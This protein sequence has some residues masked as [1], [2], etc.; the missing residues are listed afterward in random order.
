MRSVAALQALPICGRD[1]NCLS[2]R[3]CVHAHEWRHVPLRVACC[4]YDGVDGQ[5]LGGGF[6]PLLDGLK[7]EESARES[8]ANEEEGGLLWSL[9]FDCES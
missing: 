6:S 7:K 8:K 9:M 2:N 1:Q 5:Y 3:K 4:Q